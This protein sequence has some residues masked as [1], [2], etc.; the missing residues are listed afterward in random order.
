MQK[1]R[2]AEMQNTEMPAASDCG[3]GHFSGDDC[4]LE[5]WPHDRGDSSS[6]DP[7]GEQ[8]NPIIVGL[9]V[10]EIEVEGCC[11]AGDQRDSVAE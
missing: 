9:T 6:A 3:T 5:A 2:N 8:N 1:C 7:I 4:H 11:G 10:V